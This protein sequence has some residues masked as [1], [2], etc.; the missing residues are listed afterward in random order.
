MKC[1]TSYCRNEARP[2]RDICP[3]CASRK[4]RRENPV[5]ASYLNLKHNAK[6]RGKVFTLSFEEFAA[7]SVE[8]GYMKRKGI[9]KRSW[10]IDR[11]R[12]E[13]GYTKDN[14]QVLENADN[15]RKY[16]SYSYDKQGKPAN[17]K[18]MTY[19]P[20]PVVEGVPF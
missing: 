11:I 7:F 2:G 19:K 5:R 17:F 16:L 10:H 18:T 3:K 12:E 4:W 13:G 1:K 20:Q 9:F 8:S 6:R 15:V 14:I